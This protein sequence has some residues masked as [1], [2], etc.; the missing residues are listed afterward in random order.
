VSEFFLHER[1][2]R[3][4]KTLQRLSR[5]RITVCGAGALGANLCE[6]LARTGAGTL[7]V[8]DKDRIEPHNLSTQPYFKSDVGS[9]KARILA[10]NLYRALGTK[11]EAVP[12]ELTAASLDKLLK[13]SE[14]VVDTFDNSVSRQL[15]SDWCRQ[16]EVAC[17]HA[18]LA[19]GFAEV[20][21]NEVYRVPSPA[22]GQDDC[23]YPLA[24]NLVM[25]TVAVTAEVILTWLGRDQ[26]ANYTITLDD[27]A[28]RP[29][30]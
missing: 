28:V 22:A 14:L 21:W 17:L 4:E 25:L 11:I 2:A 16:R 18:G 26:Q 27:L 13:D 1:L 9:F 8:I 30:R 7:R 24:R 12:E 20:L 23:N 10:H 5:C 3:S 19:A 6:T 15:V 29:F